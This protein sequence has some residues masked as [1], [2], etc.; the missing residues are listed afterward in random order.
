MSD[1]LQA[2]LKLSQK[3][4][5]INK[6]FYHNNPDKTNNNSEYYDAVAVKIQE[7]LAEQITCECGAVIA[8]S[9]NARHK[10]TKKHMKNMEK[11]LIDT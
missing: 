11:K 1:Y 6:E 3:I 8:R 2:K 4:N 7:Y 9:G 10:R 5:K